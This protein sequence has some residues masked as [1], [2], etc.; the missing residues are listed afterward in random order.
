MFSIQSKYEIIGELG[1]IEIGETIR[2]ISKQ[3]ELLVFSYQKENRLILTQ[4]FNGLA[5]QVQI[6]IKLLNQD[7]KRYLLIEYHIDKGLIV[8]LLFVLLVNIGILACLKLTDF[9]LTGNIGYDILLFVLAVLIALGI[10][11]ATF[12][13]Q[14]R[15]LR[16]LVEYRLYLKYKSKL[17]K[18]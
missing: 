10:M 16:D 5:F 8:V 6:S 18:I 3:N 2:K 7:Q 17:S 15:S 11:N 14:S 9:V 4:K 12:S 13:E 1:F